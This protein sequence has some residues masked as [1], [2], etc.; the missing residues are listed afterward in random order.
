MPKMKMRIEK[1]DDQIKYISILRKH[2]DKSISEIKE[3]IN[4]NDFILSYN[5]LD[6]D[7]LKE[8]KNIISLLEK[9]GAKMHIYE[10]SR[11]VSVEFLDNLIESYLDT[12]RYLEE[13]DE[14]INED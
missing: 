6:I 1:D 3:A 2:T 8:M 10:D 14:Q 5:L 13:V 7:E 9:A 12:E 11:E 4:K